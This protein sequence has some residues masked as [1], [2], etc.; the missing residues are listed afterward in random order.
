MGTKA[1]SGQVRHGGRK[2]RFGRQGSWPGRSSQFIDEFPWETLIINDNN[3][4]GSRPVMETG[5]FSPRWVNLIS[6]R[7]A[8][9]EDYSW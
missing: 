9:Q 3:L 6:T 4:T 7:T 5:P 1:M 2:S 8:V